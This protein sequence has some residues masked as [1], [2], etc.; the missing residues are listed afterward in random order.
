ML[1]PRA[2]T[3]SSQVK[4]RTNAFDIQQPLNNNITEQFQQESNSVSS[5]AVVN[6]ATKTNGHVSALTTAPKNLD[7]V[8]SDAAVNGVSSVSQE[9]MP[10]QPSQTRLHRATTANVVHASASDKTG[11]S[12]VTLRNAIQAPTIFSPVKAT[13]SKASLLSSSQERMTSTQSSLARS[14]AATPSKRHFF[15]QPAELSRSNSVTSI[16]SFTSDSFVEIPEKR[17]QSVRRARKPAC[18][19]CEDKQQNGVTSQNRATKSAK[20]K[21]LSTPVGVVDGCSVNTCLKCDNQNAPVCN[22][23]PCHNVP[24]QARADSMVKSSSVLGYKSSVLRNQQSFV[25]SQTLIDQ[26]AT[27]KINGAVQS[28]PL[29]PASQQAQNMRELDPTSRS[30][31]SGKGPANSA[32][33]SPPK[34]R[35]RARKNQ[36]K[37]SASMQ[38][39]SQGTIF[40]H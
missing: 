26:N 8:C 7:P 10:K 6:A 19:C 24:I 14:T 4:T 27:N 34:T 25:S 18:V 17:Q 36:G 31:V 3:A 23:V 13:L 30:S 15:S 29:E 38:K 20:V 22:G 1:A 11:V 28:N 35:S 16:N 2:Q 37:D 5:H 40:I 21:P 9:S 33:F 39:F 12:V 32:M